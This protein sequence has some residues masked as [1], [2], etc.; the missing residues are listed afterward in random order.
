M[1]RVN[2]PLLSFGASG[3]LAKTLVY[4]SYR[5]A[6]V[7]KTL[8][9]P[10]NANST[11]QQVTRG[12]F[13]FASSLW[14]YV[15]DDMRQQWEIKAKSERQQA[16]NAFLQ[17]VVHALRGKANLNDLRFMYQ[18]EGMIPSYGANVG[19]FAGSVFGISN[20]TDWPT[21]FTPVTRA[22]ACIRQQD[23]YSPGD[24]TIY[25]AQ[26]PGAGPNPVI[27]GL[28]TGVQFLCCAWYVAENAT[29][30]RGTTAAIATNRVIP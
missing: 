29:G 12:A 30:R 10:V 11:A 18:S 24:M 13:T 23:P 21:G 5:S 4:T 19:A 27:S 1:A 25:Y 15:G 3:A 22:L 14:N 20:F 6:K 17:Q 28:P 2:G 16:R 8:G 7:V 9:Q 26:Q